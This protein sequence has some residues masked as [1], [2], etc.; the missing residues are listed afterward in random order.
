MKAR[1]SHSRWK[2]LAFAREAGGAAAIAPVCKAMAEE[3]WELLLLGKDQGLDVFR[4][5]KLTCID[6]PDFDA[7]ALEDIICHNLGSYP[8]IILTSASSLPTEM[9]CRYLWRWGQRHGIPTVGILDQWQNYALRFSGPD[10]SDY[11]AYVPD[12]IFVMDELARRGMIGD[13]IPLERIIITGQPAFDN[14][15]D[16]FQLLRGDVDRIKRQLNIDGNC[17]VTYVG[18]SLKEAYGDTLGYDEQSVLEF[19]GDALDNFCSEKL[20]LKLCLI[21]KLHPENKRE[22]FES[23]IQKW[24]SFEKRIVAKELSTHEVIS[25]SDIVVG[26]SSI[27]LVESILADKPTVSLQLNSLVDSQLMATKTGA[28]PFIVS[29]ESGRELLYRIIADASFSKQYV[30]QQKTWNIHENATA[31]CLSEIR[32]I[33]GGKRKNAEGCF[34]LS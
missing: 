10:K 16:N 3:G 30:E 17:T 12:F 26:M 27:M 15:R 4:N 20:K 2:V 9:T 1:L 24:P 33:L 23:V 19:L 21:V 34:S 8:D 14:I 28:I 11:L 7:A 6:F 22:E 25:I 18:E 32:N 31:K 5:K 13:G 29:P